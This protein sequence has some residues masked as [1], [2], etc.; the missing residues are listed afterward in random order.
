[1]TGVA[2]ESLWQKNDRSHALASSTLWAA[3]Y[4]VRRPSYVLLTEVVVGYD[5]PCAAFAPWCG[6]VTV[7]VVERAH[8]HHHART[9]TG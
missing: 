2:A 5:I 7:V 6:S 9:R 3:V 4:C 8:K 1:M